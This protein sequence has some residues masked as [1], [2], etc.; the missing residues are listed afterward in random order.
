MEGGNGLLDYRLASSEQ[1]FSYIRNED[2]FNI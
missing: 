1:Y 2:K